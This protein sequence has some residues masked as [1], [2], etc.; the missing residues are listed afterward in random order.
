MP[1]LLVLFVYVIGVHS[2][3][4]Q[5][6]SQWRGPS[7]DGVLAAAVIP[8]QWP[9]STK[10]AWEVEIGEGYSSPIVAGGRA[11]VH[12]RRDPDE[13][14]TA[15][16]L[17]SGTI[18]WQR[19][20]S[21]AF[22]KNQYA[23]AMAKGPNSTPIVV[24]TRLFTLGATG[25]LTAWNTAD[26]SI[27][28]RHDYS[29]SVDTSKLFCGTS[30]SPMLEGGSLIVQ[31]GSDVHG[32]RV[33]ALDPATGKERWAWKGL[34]PGYASPL[35]VTIDGVR[36]IITMT[37]GSI[38]GIGAANGTPLWSI[39]FADDWHENI[40]S[41]LWT[42][43]SLIVSGPRQGTHSYA[44][45]RTEA[46]AWQTKQIW[47]NADVTMYTVA[48]V[49][50]DGIIYGMSNKRRGQFVAVRASDGWLKWS[51]AG[52]DGNHASILQH[53]EHLLF[54]TDE[55]VLIVAKRTAEGFA[56][57]RRYELSQSPTWS[58]PVMLPDGI[59]VRD[60]SG[61]VKLLWE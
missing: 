49:F 24:G 39:P 35:A 14:V 32:G 58:M 56:E 12:S 2:A 43:T 59:L 46:G 50:V 22:A 10:R 30:M 5:D 8:K 17:A 47:K 42:G 40:V 16:D 33:L 18:A 7:R 57:E 9:K 31:V 15:I 60:A 52:R 26:G 11:F 23:T 53:G 20:Y 44:I 51:T 41:P 6:W 36:Q 25:I 37:D 48:P 21:A 19:K 27:A 61:V 54:L 38:V 1:S 13:I 29:S 34:G 3:A 4:A 45:T 28:W 55:G